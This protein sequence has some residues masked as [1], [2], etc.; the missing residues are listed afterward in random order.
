MLINSVFPIIEFGMFYGL[1]FIPRLMDRAYSC[2]YEKYNTKTTSIMQYVD[3]YAGPEFLMHFKYSAILNVIFVTFMYGLGL[4]LLFVY[5]VIAMVVLWF[6]EEVLFYYS[7]RLPPMYD[8]TLGLNVINK[9]KFAPL[10]LLIFGY[11]F[12]S[13]NQLYSN[14]QLK[15]FERQSD[16]FVTGHTFLDPFTPAGWAAPAWP[17]LLV[18]IL[19]L[20]H[21]IFGEWLGEA[22]AYFFPSCKIGDI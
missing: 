20:V 19:L 13:S 17:L 15:P 4:P 2:K 11:W 3:L 1:R 14:D 9:M 18:F 21:L 6:S 5:A 8:E 7:Y 16:T 10:F 22:V 12:Y